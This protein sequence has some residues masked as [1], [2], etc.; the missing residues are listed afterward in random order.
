MH[1]VDGVDVA[2]GAMPYVKIAWMEIYKHAH[3]IIARN[4]RFSQEWPR[5][6]LKYRV[7]Y[8]LISWCIQKKQAMFVGC[9]M[10]L[11]TEKRGDKQ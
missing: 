2:G 1:H 9:M 4:A 7:R 6:S 8:L 10:L 5:I 3:C 11:K